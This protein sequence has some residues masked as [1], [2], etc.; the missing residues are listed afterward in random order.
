MILLSN[1]S[2]NK[3]DLKRIEHILKKSVDWNKVFHLSLSE[4]TTFIIYKNLLQYRYFW[5]VP[6]S[7][8][9]VWDAAY[10]GNIRRNKQ[11]L[12]YTFI[13]EQKFLEQK[14][15]AISG[16]GIMLLSNIYK[17]ML[18]VRFL[19]DLDFFTEKEN[20]AYIDKILFDLNF[21]KIYINNHDLLTM[22]IDIEE[23]DVLYSKFIGST[24]INCDFCSGIK[25]KPD[26]FKYLINCLKSKGSCDY[27]TALLVTLYL[28]AEK[29]WNNNYY[30]P[31]IKHYTYAKLID[32]YLF[33]ISIS[34]KIINIDKLSY[35][36]N[37]TKMIQD[38]DLVLDFF[39]KEGYLS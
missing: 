19:H 37:L 27:Y 31:N 9:T 8:R 4:N 16:N 39:K 3:L 35:R 11:L 18:G 32:L 7:L 36:F 24:Y 26:L 14:I 12:H 6:D 17:D 21:K 15:I 34:S 20:L 10:L 28:S 33:K 2:L 22:P 29:S 38:V 25:D 5:L 23:N 1:P 30:V 13:L